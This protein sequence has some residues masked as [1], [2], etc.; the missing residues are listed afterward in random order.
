MGNFPGNLACFGAFIL[1]ELEGLREA[2]DEG[3]LET[4]SSLPK[5]GG[6]NTGLDTGFG[7][8]LMVTEATALKRFLD[9]TG[10][11]PENSGVGSSFVLRIS[12]SLLATGSSISLVCFI[13]LSFFFAFSSS[14]GSSFVTTGS[15]RVR[16]SALWSAV[17]SSTCSFLIFKMGA[18]VEE[19]GIASAGSG[20]SE[21]ESSLS[22]TN[23]SYSPN[24]WSKD[25]RLWTSAAFRPVTS[26]KACA[27]ERR[28]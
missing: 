18:F 17:L 28:R 20:G 16:L 24:F 12:G 26:G 27:I 25:L 22:K 23:K 10:S 21:E 1:L 19:D 7:F 6:R 13:L 14:G 9:F 8:T 5:L 15:S 11:L 3:S 4:L 2:V